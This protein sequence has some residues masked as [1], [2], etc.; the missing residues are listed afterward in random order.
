MELGIF[1]N[2]FIL[3][4]SLMAMFLFGFRLNNLSLLDISINPEDRKKKIIGI[5]YLRIT[6]FLNKLFES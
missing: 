6:Y 1:F 2:N 5:S 4:N 3:A